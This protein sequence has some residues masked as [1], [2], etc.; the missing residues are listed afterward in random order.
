MT[1]DLLYKGELVG[2]ETRR[3]MLRSKCSLCEGTTA[4]GQRIACRPG[5]QN[6]VHVTCLDQL[7]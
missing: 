2:E 6:W 7:D 3:A 5:T 1:D 4:I